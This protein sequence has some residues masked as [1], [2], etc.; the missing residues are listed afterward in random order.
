MESTS[1][2]TPRLALWSSDKRPGAHAP[3]LPP[4]PTAYFH[5]HA[6]P[7]DSAPKGLSRWFEK[8][9]LARTALGTRP[10]QCAERHA[11]R[12]QGGAGRRGSP[13]RPRRGRREHALSPHVPWS[14]RFSHENRLTGPSR[15]GENQ[16][17]PQTRVCGSQQSYEII[18]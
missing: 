9:L 1:P 14:L 8:H 16:D 15:N 3:R 11:E 7:L 18:V 13:G 2:P 6:G 12:K 10:C 5:G 4:S 17:L